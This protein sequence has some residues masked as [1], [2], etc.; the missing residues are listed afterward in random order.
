MLATGVEQLASQGLHMAQEMFAQT[1]MQSRSAWMARKCVIT[2]SQAR[3]K[4]NFF[5]FAFGSNMHQVRMK[6]APSV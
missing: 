6:C 1:E 5:A 3:Y 4:R 2:T